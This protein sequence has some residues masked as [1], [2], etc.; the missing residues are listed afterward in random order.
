MTLKIRVF[1]FFAAAFAAFGQTA[2]IN[3]IV[4]DSSGAVIP[5]AQ[6]TLTNTETG[7]N[8]KATSS[9]SGAYNFNLLPVL[10]TY[11]NVE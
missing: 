6:V 4:T 5:G 7:L 10:S 11:E 2:T 8:Q 9:G 3:G 1:L